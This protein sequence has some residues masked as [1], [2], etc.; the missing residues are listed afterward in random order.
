M[1][2]APPMPA[3]QPAPP[4]MFGGPAQARPDAGRQDP[5]WS[6]FSRGDFGR[7]EQVRP[8][9]VRPDQGWAEQG[10][11]PRPDLGRPD[12]G[13]PDLGRSDLGRSDLGRP[14][15]GRPAPGR[16]DAPAQPAGGWPYVGT[17]AAPPSARP[18]K[19]KKGLFIIL[20]IVVGVVL[21]AGAATI[22]Y[23]VMSG[24]DDYPVGSC[25]RQ[26][27]SRPTVVDCSE[28][29]AF[30]V[31]STVGSVDQCPD[32]AQ[33]AIVLKDLGKSDKFVCLQPVATG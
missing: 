31:V 7:T 22:G 13:R 12:L 6:D 5:G 33:P 24:G 11:P 9:Q 10:Q 28:S 14:E 29:G 32:P 16:P 30:K 20:A 3:T 17:P 26:D 8:E 27:G 4:P 23:I 21:L 15:P 1:A 19:S 18:A 2:A 25:V